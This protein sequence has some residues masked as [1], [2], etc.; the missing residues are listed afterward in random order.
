MM[1]MNMMID[2]DEEEHDRCLWVFTE[3]V[4]PTQPGTLPGLGCW[5]DHG[6][7]YSTVL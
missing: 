4:E 5:Q 6:G 2:G 7:D 3:S 1:E